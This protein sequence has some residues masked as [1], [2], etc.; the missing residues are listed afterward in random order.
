MA[1]VT[2][3]QERDL[4]NS[5]VRWG[6]ASVLGRVQQRLQAVAGGA[7]V[8]ICSMRSIRT[9]A[10]STGAGRARRCSR[11]RCTRSGCRVTAGERRGGLGGGSL[12]IDEVGGQAGCRVGI[13]PGRSPRLDDELGVQRPR[14]RLSELDATIG[15]GD[16]W[17]AAQTFC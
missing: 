16:W 8:R 17:T 4:P 3:P 9:L 7:M 6:H 1:V 10:A 12:V 11:A 15:H 13:A 5:V 2:I 14:Q